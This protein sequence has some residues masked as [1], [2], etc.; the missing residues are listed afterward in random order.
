VIVDGSFALVSG[1]IERV[2][3]LVT[4]HEGAVASSYP[5]RLTAPTESWRS[6]VSSPVPW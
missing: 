3:D 2:Q 5:L 4:I 6:A 1:F